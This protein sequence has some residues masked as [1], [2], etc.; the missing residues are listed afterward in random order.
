MTTMNDFSRQLIDKIKNIDCLEVVKHNNDSGF[1]NVR[2]TTSMHPRR[3][4]VI[5][6]LNTNTGNMRLYSD[7]KWVSANKLGITSL[8]AIISWVKKDIEVLTSQKV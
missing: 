2:C 8:E 4:N 7:G 1:I 5:G 6:D 3:F